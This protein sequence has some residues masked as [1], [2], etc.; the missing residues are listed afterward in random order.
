MSVLWSEILFHSDAS[1][2]TEFAT[3]KPTIYLPKLQ[4]LIQLFSFPFF[5][6][7]YAAI[8]AKTSSKVKPDISQSE[9][10]FHNDL[11]FA[12]K[13]RYPIGRRVMFVSALELQI[14]AALLL[15]VLIMRR[16]WPSG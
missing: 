14:N 15:A 11:G 12:T 7:H 6:V 4:L 3:I 5:K 16:A 10:T 1:R 8:T 2:K 13:Y 9:S